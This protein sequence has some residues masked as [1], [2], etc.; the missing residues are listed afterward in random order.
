MLS[1]KNSLHKFYIR[2]PYGQ[3][4]VYAALCNNRVVERVSTDN[5]NNSG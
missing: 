4:I 1:V 5:L 2:C 3:R